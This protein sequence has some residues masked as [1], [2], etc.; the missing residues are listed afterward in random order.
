MRWPPRRFP[1]RCGPRCRPG[2]GRRTPGG[3]PCASPMSRILRHLGPGR[4]PGSRSR[5]TAAR[6]WGRSRPSRR[7]PVLWMEGRS[8]WPG[9][10]RG[11]TRPEWSDRSGRRASSPHTARP[12]SV[13]ARGAR[14]PGGPPPRPAVRPWPLGGRHPVGPPP[15]W[16]PRRAGLGRRW[17]RRGPG[18][19]TRRPGDRTTVRPPRRWLATRWPTGRSTAPGPPIPVRSPPARRVRGPQ[20]ARQPLPGGRGAVDGL[21]RSTGRPPGSASRR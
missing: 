10:L 13:P 2:P 21:G 11:R 4:R 19:R 3:V 12:R 20:E 16:A 8:T 9:S 18:A 15:R 6:L 17:N 7:P 1:R 5:G 14:R